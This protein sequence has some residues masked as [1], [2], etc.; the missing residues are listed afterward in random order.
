MLVLSVVNM[1]EEAASSDNVEYLGGNISDLDNLFDPANLAC[2]NEFADALCFLAFHPTADRALADYVRS[3]TLPDDSGPRTLV[4]F[5]LDQPVPGAVRVGSDS[6]RVWAEITAGVHPAYEAVR[7]LYAGQPAPPLPGLVL[8]DD[9]AHGERTIYLP[10]ASLTSEQDVRAH[11]RQVFSLVDHVVAGAKPGR[12]LDDLGYALR[13]HGLAFHRTGRTPVRE[14]LLRV[15]QLA[16]KHRGDVV[17][18]IG[19]LK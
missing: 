15:V 18:V 13:K 5:T 10:L 16:R 7:A 8:F 14:W 11:L 12:F 1:L 4:M 6:M 2:L 3:G 9:L 17:S 19:L